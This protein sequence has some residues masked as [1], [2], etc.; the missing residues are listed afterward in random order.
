[1]KKILLGF[2]FILL[3]LFSFFATR[4]YYQKKTSI[5]PSLAGWGNLAETLSLTKEQEKEIQLLENKYAHTCETLCQEM[6]QRRISLSQEIMKSE[7][8]PEQI[9]ALIDEISCLQGQMEKE[10]IRHILA[11]KKTLNLKQQKAFISSI[12]SELKRICC[13]EGECQFKRRMGSMHGRPRNGGRP[14]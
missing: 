5:H 1:M 6:N 3:V 2:T 4:A 13:P 12:S 9:N 8:D 10:T 14:E 11:V 7:P